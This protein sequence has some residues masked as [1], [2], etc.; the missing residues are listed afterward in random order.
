MSETERMQLSDG[1]SLEGERSIGKTKL[2]SERLPT[3]HNI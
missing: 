1:P 3:R 2:L